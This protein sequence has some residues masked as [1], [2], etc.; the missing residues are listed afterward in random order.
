VKP[1]AGLKFNANEPKGATIFSTVIPGTDR[2][3]YFTKI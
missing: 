1:E 3:I 2:Y